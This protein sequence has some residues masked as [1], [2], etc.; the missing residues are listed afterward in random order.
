MGIDGGS[1]CRAKDACGTP[2]LTPQKVCCEVVPRMK[3]V[4]ATR[5]M[6]TRRKMCALKHSH[7]MNTAVSQ[8]LCPNQQECL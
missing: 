6:H 2:T 3:Y 8:L 1:Q 7:L 4:G 5:A